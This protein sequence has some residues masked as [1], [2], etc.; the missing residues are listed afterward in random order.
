MVL[1][2]G[3]SLGAKSINDAVMKNMDTFFDEKKIRL[4]WATGKDNFQK[5][6]ESVGK[7]KNNDIIKPY[8]FV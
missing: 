3:G 4:Y 8:F 1:V 7:T 5:V 2:I 6:N